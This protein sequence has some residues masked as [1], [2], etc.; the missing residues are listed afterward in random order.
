MIQTKAW[1]RERFPIVYE[2]G[3]PKAVLVDIDVFAQVEIIL[4]NLLNRKGEPEDLLLTESGL[5][6]KLIQRAQETTASADWARQ[7]SEL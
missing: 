1:S 3:E 2:G 7:C 6:A 4:E 5:L